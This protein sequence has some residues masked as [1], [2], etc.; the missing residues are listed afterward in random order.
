MAFRRNPDEDGSEKTDEG[1]AAVA[2][3]AKAN[4]GVRLK[5]KKKKELRKVGK[6]RK[7][8][9]VQQKGMDGVPKG[10]KRKSEKSKK[11]KR[12]LV[13]DGER[14]QMEILSSIFG[15]TES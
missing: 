2:V 3:G 1:A 9:E 6:T 10:G 7:E 11:K 15:G 12:R 13:K 14:K 5:K 8:E 4:D